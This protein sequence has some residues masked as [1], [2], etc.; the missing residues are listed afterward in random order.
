[1]FVEIVILVIGIL[2]CGIFFMFICS[3][4]LENL[5]DSV[6]NLKRNGLL[7]GEEGNTNERKETKERNANK[8][9]ENLKKRINH[10]NP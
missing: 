1:M 5:V 6:I 9:R 2:I 7:G 3:L 10:R 8:I 4:F